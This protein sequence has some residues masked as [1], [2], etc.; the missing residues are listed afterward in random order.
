[1]RSMLPVDGRACGSAGAAWASCKVSIAPR[2]A[3]KTVETKDGMKN[4]LSVIA[5]AQPRRPDIIAS[6]IR[7]QSAIWRTSTAC[8]HFT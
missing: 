7:I 3:H 1:M 8:S 4:S 6:L 2:Q 5:G